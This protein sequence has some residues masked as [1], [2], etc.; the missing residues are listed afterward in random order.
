MKFLILRPQKFAL[1][2]SAFTNDFISLQVCSSLNHPSIVIVNSPKQILIAT[3]THPLT[4][5]VNLVE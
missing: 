1:A 3:Q 5:L 2:L 4:P